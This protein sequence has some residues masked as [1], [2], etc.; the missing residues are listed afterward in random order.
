MYNTSI[1]I[2]ALIRGTHDII[3]AS[4][5]TMATVMAFF[6][7]Y[8]VHWFQATTYSLCTGWLGV[9][10]TL[11]ERGCIETS[12]LQ[13]EQLP[14]PRDMLRPVIA[15]SLSI[16]LATCIVFSGYSLNHESTQCGLYTV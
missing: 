10:F 13:G 6:T 4:H 7:V 11:G 5:I 14:Q 8:T 3:A 15:L 1:I 12:H 9:K 16:Y 2:V